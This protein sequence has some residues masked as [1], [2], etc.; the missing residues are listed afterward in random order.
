MERSPDDGPIRAVALI[1]ARRGSKRIPDKNIRTLAGHPLLAYAID[2][3]RRSGVFGDVVLSTDDESYAEIGTRYG[4]SVPFLRPREL[5]G[6]A[7]TDV[8]WV[9][10]ALRELSARGAGFDVF[11]IL[12]PTSPFRTIE[13]IQRAWSAFS[14]AIGVDSL[15]AVEPCEQ[16]PGKMWRIIGGRLVPVL[17]VQPLG[18]PWHSSPTQSLPAVWVQN[19]SLEIAWSRCVLEGGSIA[20]ESII[21]FVTRFPEGLDLNTEHD[22]LRAEYLLATGAV[23][24]P[25]I[26]APGDSISS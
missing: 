2:A 4:A 24:L 1:P 8:E 7:S 6:D 5:A 16:H 3:A 10:H 22:W 15:R 20:G 21:P 25:L 12:R 23:S 13:T 17:P 19:A 11:S 26:D 9:D 18:T 14:R